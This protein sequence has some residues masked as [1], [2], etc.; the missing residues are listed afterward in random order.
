MFI[1]SHDKADLFACEF[2]QKMKTPEPDR[3]LYTLPCLVASSLESV[4]ISEE[5]ARRH[6]KGINT[7]K[8]P[9]HDGVSPNLLKHCAEELT[10]LVVMIFRQCLLVRVWPSQWKEARA[11]LVRIKKTR[12]NQSYYRPISLLSVVSNI[13]ERIIGEQLRSFLEEYYLQ[14]S[15]QFGFRRS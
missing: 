10:R 4:I 7:K 1:T 5:A 8:A 14:S 12:S 11:K 6:L 2:S 9:G 13:F 3:K 15:R